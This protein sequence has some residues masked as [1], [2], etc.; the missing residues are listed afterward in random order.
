MLH[1]SPHRHRAAG[2]PSPRRGEGVKSCAG[3]DRGE[4]ATYGEVLQR[5]RVQTPPTEPFRVLLYV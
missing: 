1:P 3:S 5:D 4:A 2:P